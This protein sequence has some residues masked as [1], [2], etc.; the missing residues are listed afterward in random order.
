MKEEKLFRA[1]GDVGGDLIDMAEKATFAPSRWRRWGSVAACLAVLAGLAALALPYVTGSGDEDSTEVVLEAKLGAAREEFA[2]DTTEAPAEAESAE[3][4]S[5][6]AESDGAVKA[7]LTDK[8]GLIDKD[9][10][11]ASSSREQLIF[12]GVI[13]YVEALYS[14]EEAMT[15]LGAYL[16]TVEDADEEAYIGDRIYMKSGSD[17]QD[18]LPLEIFVMTEEG[19]LYC[20]T[21]YADAGAYCTWED[22]AAEEDAELL[23]RFVRAVEQG[24]PD[25]PDLETPNLWNFEDPSELSAD[26]LAAWFRLML[27][28][29]ADTGYRSV[30]LYSYFWLQPM[31][32]LPEDAEDELEGGCYVIPMCDVTGVL[33]RYLDG[34]TLDPSEL[35]GSYDAAQNALILDVIDVSAAKEPAVALMLRAWVFE[36]ASH[37]MRLT[38]E[39]YTDETCE[40]LSAVRIYTIRFENDCCYYDSIVTQESITELP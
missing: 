7:G 34:Y 4:E 5:A 14:D 29:Q 38:V 26:Q 13:Y 23:K 15:Q 6:E 36:E 35:T 33:D 24:I 19:F 22:A 12:D 30:D 40:V 25:S 1:I 11:D 8:D 17:E 39:R 9:G 3:E 2:A 27:N 16:G 10:I 37:T 21:Y 18:G 20:L 31:V 28:Q 32:T